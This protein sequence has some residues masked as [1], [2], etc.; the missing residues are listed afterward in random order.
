MKLLSIIKI[1]GEIMSY[2]KWSDSMSVGVTLMDE[3]HKTII[4]LINLLHENIHSKKDTKNISSIINVLVNYTI[5]HFEREEKIMQSA[6][7]PNLELHQKKH[8]SLKDEVRNIAE[9]Y[10]E[11]QNLDQDKLL[12]FLKDWLN[13]HILKEDMQ[14]RTF[15]ENN[16]EVIKLCDTMHALT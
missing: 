15:C 3:D 12:T 4:T 16:E 13:N 11:G 6:N 14:Y 9:L 5:F 10:D 2:F 7:Y 1:Y 8:A